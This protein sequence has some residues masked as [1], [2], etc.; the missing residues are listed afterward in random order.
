MVIQESSAWL[1]VRI[2][3]GVLFCALAGQT[4]MN[5]TDN[6]KIQ[7]DDFTESSKRAALWCGAT[8]NCNRTT[9]S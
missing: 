2:G 3:F 6:A 8:S 5:K 7:C 1:T 9:S 4:L